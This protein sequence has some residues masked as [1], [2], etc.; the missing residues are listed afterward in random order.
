[1]LPRTERPRWPALA[2]ILILSW[3]VGRDIPSWIQH[4]G[5]A[6][7]LWT[8][9]FTRVK[10]DF[11]TLACGIESYLV[12]H[13]ALPPARVLTRGELARSGVSNA[14]AGL[15]TLDVR[16]L[17]TPIAY[18]VSPPLDKFGGSRD[19]HFYFQGRFFRFEETPD[20][21]PYLYHPEGTEWLLWSAGPDHRYELQHPKALAPESWTVLPGRLGPHQYDPTN[22]SRSGGDIYQGSPRCNW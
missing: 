5:Y 1:M 11:R 12:D 13:G 10:R 9:G 20:G 21:L 14:T 8:S 18:L 4:Q 17:T 19:F 16:V 2:I 15:T 22:G 7:I 3:F 6:C